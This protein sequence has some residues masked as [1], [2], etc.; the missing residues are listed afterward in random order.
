MCRCSGD[1]SLTQAVPPDRLLEEPVLLNQYFVPLEASVGGQPAFTYENFFL[2][3]AAD[4]KRKTSFS[5][6]IYFTF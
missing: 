3:R 5:L 2:L 1:F 4:G 6:E